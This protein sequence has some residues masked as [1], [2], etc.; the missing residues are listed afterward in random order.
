MV[1]P[2]DQLALAIGKEG[3]NARLAARLTGWKVDI[4][5][6]VEFA[7]GRGRGRLG[8]GGADEEFS[9]RCAAI[10]SNG[11]RCPN[12]RCRAPASA[13]SRRT[14]SSRAVSRRRACERDGVV[15][16]RDER[17]GRS[18]EAE[19]EEPTARRAVAEE[20]KSE[21]GRAARGSRGGGRAASWRAD[22]ACAGCGRKAPKVGALP[23]S[24]SGRAFSSAE[25]RAGAAAASTRASGSPASS[26]QR[27]REL[28]PHAQARSKSIPSS[29]RSLQ[30]IAMA[31]ESG[32]NRPNRPTAGAA[33]AVAGASAAS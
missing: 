31:N 7:A 22:Q 24:S 15:P 27:P 28:Q 8:G 33:P 18:R 19:A 2:E 5:C 29:R 26:A 10:L 9:G 11:K 25:G 20:A 32:G 3:L 13:A 16:G 23:R 17:H 21:P 30:S 1:V 6:D 14:R 4:Q 12:A